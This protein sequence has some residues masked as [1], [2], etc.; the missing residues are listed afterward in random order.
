MAQVKE[1]ADNRRQLQYAADAAWPSTE[2]VNAGIRTEF[3]I[4]PNR[5]LK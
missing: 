5:A 3:K 4:P 1:V 2:K